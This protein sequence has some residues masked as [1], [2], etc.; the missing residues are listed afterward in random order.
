MFE[1]VADAL[2]SAADAYCLNQPMPEVVDGLLREIVAEV[3][4]LPPPPTDADPKEDPLAEGTLSIDDPAV[5]LAGGIASNMLRRLFDRT[6]PPLR[7][8]A[9][10]HD[11]LLPAAE[12]S[13]EPDRWRLVSNPPLQAL[14]SVCRDLRDLHAVV[15]EQEGGMYAH[16]ALVRY[17]RRARSRRPLTAAAEWAHQQARTRLM[18]SITQSERRLGEQGLTGQIVQRAERKPNGVLWPAGELAVFVRVS[19]IRDWLTA[20]PILLQECG[21][22]FGDLRS[23]VIAPIREEQAVASLGGRVTSRK[24]FPL[25]D[26]FRAWHDDLTLPFLQERVGSAFDTCLMA[27][28]EL[29]GIV[30]GGTGNEIHDREAEVA[31]AVSQRWREGYTARAALEPQDPG[32]VIAL[33]LELLNTLMAV[34]EE[35]Q[36][37]VVQGN[38]PPDLAATNAVVA[39]LKGDESYLVPTGVVNIARLALMEWDVEPQGA[40]ERLND[41]TPAATG[42]ATSSARP[43]SKK[44][45][46]KRA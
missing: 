39:A 6:E 10:I 43:P 30:A 15:A 46:Q 44:R 37:S 45:R 25:P 11:T 26:Q 12:Q 40:M 21:R 36:Q 16:Q 23:I 20:Q 42:T 22:M 32:Q 27:L 19:T 24:Y 31:D 33:A 34:V 41:P 2:A 5:T 38:A 18:Q 35:Q 4:A 17:A 13:R 29:T 8:A 3:D 28:L 7:L 9:Y 1:T 14:E